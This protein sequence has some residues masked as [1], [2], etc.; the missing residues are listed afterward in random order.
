VLET[1]KEKNLKK[2][3][4]DMKRL[5]NYIY[6]ELEESL[7]TILSKY[8]EDMK[9]LTDRYIEDF[10]ADI[11]IVAKVPFNTKRA[12]AAGLAGVAAYGGLA[13]W[14]STIASNLGAYI[15]VVKG[16][17]LLSALGVSISGGTAT[18]TAFVAAIGG[19][20]VL[21]IALAGIAAIA[22]FVAFSGGWEKRVAKQLIR[23]YEVYKDE[24]G[25][26]T[27]V[28]EIYKKGIG[29]FWNDTKKAFN[30]GA[31]EMEKE[32]S[33]Y[34]NNLRKLVEKAKNGDDEELE[35]LQ[36]EKEAQLDFFAEE[37]RLHGDG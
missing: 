26:T 22:G 29:K 21:G 13:F 4:K 14:V 35:K 5:G 23:A 24:D 32:W 3:K 16:V 1:I 36:K 20:V 15:L 27:G 6:T 18:A 7:Q 12:F 19:P 31:D 37:S 2:K 10:D 9:E 30:K 28:L 8:S 17:S 33:D 25:N 34:V 11:K